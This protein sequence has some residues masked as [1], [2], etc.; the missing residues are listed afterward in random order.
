MTPSGP[1]I[2]LQD[3]DHHVV[4]FDGSNEQ[5]LGRIHL[6][7][8]RDVLIALSPDRRLLAVA[9]RIDKLVSVWDV[10]S[11]E[12]I[13]RDAKIEC[14]ARALA[15]SP[16][17]RCLIVS[18]LYDVFKLYDLQSD[19]IRTIAL[20]ADR[21]STN[22]P[23]RIRP[24]A[25]FAFSPDSKFL[26]IQFGSTPGA[27]APATVWRVDGWRKEADYPGVVDWLDP[28][29]FTPDSRAL[30]LQ[31]GASVV[32]WDFLARDQPAQ[33]AGHDDEAWSLAFSP[34]GKVLASGSDNDEP[35]TISLWDV[36]TGARLR[37]W[38]GG[39]GTISALA[40]D[41]SGRILASA[42]LAE[43]PFVRLWDAADGRPIAVM[44]GHTKSIRTLAF[45]PG[46]RWLATAGSD[47][48][49]RIWDVAARSCRYVLTGHTDTVRRLAFSPDGARLVSAAN[50]R[51]LRVWDV[52]AGREISSTLC[53]DK[54]AAVAY[55]P[56]GKTL[57][58]VD[59]QGLVTIR[60]ATSHATLTTIE[61]DEPKMLCLAFSPDGLA[62]AVAGTGGDI[63]LWDPA[64]GQSLLTLEGS[65]SQVN[66]LAFSPDGLT[67]A[68]CSHDG[69]VRIWRAR[70]R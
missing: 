17:G 41:P 68:S 10:A 8:H 24:H 64:T 60:D 28:F 30:F 26:A 69:A 49:I 42:D 29:V 6:A 57:A 3:P 20:P 1:L 12:A 36:A 11:G 58:L 62:L 25:V 23:W 34:D 54:I 27:P 2:G 22:V 4:V 66:A 32:R 52:D 48:T 63:G 61:I 51:T 31:T 56:D 5:N 33:P 19:A 45:R 14:V 70:P 7:Q 13:M 47:R 37:G 21:P 59:E 38:L 55:A 50:D 15:F 46:G 16:D 40:F 18:D 43:S 39:D 9:G 35:E 44:A 65:K 67:L 53:K